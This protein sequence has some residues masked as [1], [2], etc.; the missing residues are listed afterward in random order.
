MERE[1][2]ILYINPATMKRNGFDS[3]ELLGKKWDAIPG[4]FTTHQKISLAKALLN[5]I[6]R[7][8]ATKDIP[9]DLIDKQGA[10]HPTKLSFNPI[11]I[12]NQTE[13][14]LIIGVDNIKE[15]DIKNKLKDVEHRY[16]TIAENTSDLISMS[17]FS[18]KPVF[19]Y[20]SPSNYE[21]LGFSPEE[22]IGKE[23]L[24]FVH[25]EDKKQLVAKLTYY[26]GKEVAGK[27][28]KRKEMKE[29]LCYRF[30]TKTGDY[31]LLEV[32]ANLA[33]NEILYVSRDITERARIQKELK[34][35]KMTMDYASEEVFWVDEDANILY[36]NNKASELLGYQNKEILTKTV[37]DINK[38]FTPKQW[39]DHWQSLKKT[40]SILMESS[41]WTK[42]GEEFPTEVS[43][44]FI[45]LGDQSFACAF[46]RDITERIEARQQE[47][48]YTNN[49]KHLSQSAL[50]FLDC[51]TLEEFFTIVLEQTR[52]LVAGAFLA[53][54]LYD[55]EKDAVRITAFEKGTTNIANI[56]KLLGRD[57]VGL[58]VELTDQ[59]KTEILSGKLI[60][61]QDKLYNLTGGKIPKS[62]TKSIEHILKIEKI[63]FIGFNHEGTILGSIAI[64]MPKGEDIKDVAV[65]ETLFREA[66]ITLYRLLAEQEIRRQNTELKKTDKLKSDFLNMTSHEL[67]TPMTA[68]KGYL[69][70]LNLQ[71]FGDL[72]EEQKNALKIVLRNID[73]LNMLVQDIL[74]TSRLESGTM[75]F[76]AKNVDIKELT[77]STIET[78]QSQ[79]ESK[80]ITLCSKISPNLPEMFLDPERLTQVLVNIINNAIKFSPD[81]STIDIFVA[82][83]KDHLLFT[84]T[85][86]G[87][88]IPKE[89][90]EKIFGLFHQAESGSDRKY[91]GT[92]LGLTISKAIVEAH[93]GKLWAESPGENKGSSFKFI[94]PIAK[95]CNL[96]E[97]FKQVSIFK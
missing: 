17:T 78:M 29:K 11:V 30:R 79:A 1:G 34:E 95:E 53:A 49:M 91:G 96:E 4:T 35:A 64:V 58:E 13:Y 73:R 41:E 76:L 69:E 72:N 28:V 52:P 37:Y 44:N 87:I 40:G 14:L 20:A 94:L 56:I 59:V 68:M 61:W 80:K 60:S 77:Q 25:P 31:R 19:T 12:N 86:K 75:K 74:D 32:T 65:L 18:S 50:R 38:N 6:W 21:I 88:G 63:Y 89:E 43:Y 93:G 62:I 10:V 82:Q 22:L 85:D 42:T 97:G 16:K 70:M 47:A 23:A 67:R 5:A 55:Q 57:I 15:K 27:L 51:S 36:A 45:D 66:S 54:T 33:G 39:K 48:Y 8:K 9:V 81:Q 84:I 71:T 83:Q 46:V 26:L 24:S 90:L 2:R 3:N 7:K 92:G